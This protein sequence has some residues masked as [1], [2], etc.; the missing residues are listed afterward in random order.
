MEANRK[1][2]EEEESAEVRKIHFDIVTDV[3][4]NQVKAA[5]GKG[6]AFVPFVN[7]I[8]TPILFGGKTDNFC[9]F[10]KCPPLIQK[11][12]RAAERWQMNCSSR[13][14]ILLLRGTPWR[15]K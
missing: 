1:A 3:A 8:A 6:L 4:T 9:T 14:A 2:E 11:V 12:Q 15:R 10:L 7:L 5:W 13:G